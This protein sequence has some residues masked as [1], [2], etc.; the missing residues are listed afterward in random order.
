MQ[1]VQHFDLEFDI[2]NNDSK[3]SKSFDACADL[4]LMA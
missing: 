3:I 2:T 4:F 1:I